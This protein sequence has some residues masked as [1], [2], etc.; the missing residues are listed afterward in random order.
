MKIPDAVMEVLTGLKQRG[1][2]AYLV[3][4]C[5][6]DMVRQKPPRDFDLATSARPEEVQAAFKKTLPTGIEHGTVTVLLRGV[7]VE[8]TTFRTEGAYVDARR[9]S[10][11]TFHRDIVQDLSRR[12]FTIN[13]MAYDPTDGRIVDPFGGQ[14]DLKAR[15]IRC[16]GKPE[17]RFGEDGLRAL[18]AVRFS[19][20]LGFDLHEDTEKA[21]PATLPSFR[22][23]ANERIREELT[24]LLLSERPAEGTELLARTGLLA[25]FLP[26]VPSPAPA[27]TGSR[28]QSFD[29]LRRTPDALEVRLAVLLH[30]VPSAK[31]REV[32]LRLRYPNKTCDHV[33]TL[34]RE[35]ATFDVRAP[36]ED[37]DLRR[38]MARLTPPLVEP[39]FA[40]L[41]AL[42]GGGEVAALQARASAVL[43]QNP[44]L[45]ARA[46]AVDGKRIME[47]LGVGPSRV[48]GEATRFLV[49]QVL[50]DP[51]RNDPA[52]LARL[53]QNW[54]EKT[55]V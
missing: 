38:L 35:R 18:R 3:G 12:D 21:I 1:H 53:L 27:P 34:L 39:F 15:L 44:P 47:L 43:A 20:V 32:L 36:H 25:T 55:R 26:E 46:L 30:E 28:S 29:P 4:G 23:I 11:V 14:E 41:S 42:E 2:E 13:A 50:E 51:T 24:R 48:I 52:Q 16:V 17:E 31:A 8:V 9:P 22:R 40:V 45:D 33:A 49:E 10:S 37:A 6:R 54:A 5:V 7:P 19:A